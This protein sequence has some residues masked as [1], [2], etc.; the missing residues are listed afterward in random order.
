MEE[1]QNACFLDAQ[2]FNSGDLETGNNCIGRDSLI[3]PRSRATI[4]NEPFS[5]PNFRSAPAKRKRRNI[6]PD[7]P[8]YV[9]VEQY[10]SQQ[11]DPVWSRIFE[12]ALKMGKAVFIEGTEPIIPHQQPVMSEEVRANGL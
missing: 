6:S 12:N 4:I 2:P 1:K 5:V 7:H 8:L 9:T 10:W 11:N 3:T